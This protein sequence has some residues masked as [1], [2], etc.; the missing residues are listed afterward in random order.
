MS[1][2]AGY[3]ILP[4][5]SDSGIKLFNSNREIVSLSFENIDYSLDAST[6]VL[7]LQSQQSYLTVNEITVTSSISIPIPGNY[8]TT[9]Y[10]DLS[11]KTITLTIT[12]SNFSS[13]TNPYAYV[14]IKVHP[15]SEET[16]LELTLQY[17]IDSESA[18]PI[19]KYPFSGVTELNLKVV[20]IYDK[21][22]SSFIVK[23]V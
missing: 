13:S 7:T 23:A 16:P 10:A 3:G 20:I 6:N 17:Q 9:S 8:Y 14:N 2:Y 11:S 5:T 15:T 12:E 22:N 4:S 19:A 1:T 18:V 21:S